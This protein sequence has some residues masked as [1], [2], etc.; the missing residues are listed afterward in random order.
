MEIDREAGDAGFWSWPGLEL[1][2]SDDVGFFSSSLCI[3]RFGAFFGTSIA[4]GQT[5]FLAVNFLCC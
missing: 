1:G 3:S 2:S 4:S 5:P